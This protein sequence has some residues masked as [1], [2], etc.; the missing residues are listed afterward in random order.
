MSGTCRDKYTFL[1]FYSSWRQI[2]TERLL[3]GVQILTKAALPH[4]DFVLVAQS[5]SDTEENK[6]AVMG[7]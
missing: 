7:I 6:Q 5:C 3:P 2:A 4:Q 1:P